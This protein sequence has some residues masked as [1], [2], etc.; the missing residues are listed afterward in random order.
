MPANRWLPWI[1][2]LC[3]ACGGAAKH[4]SSPAHGGVQAERSSVMSGPGEGDA[5]A[6]VVTTAD[7]GGTTGGSAAPVAAGQPAATVAGRQPV[8]EKMVIEGWIRVVV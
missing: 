5:E 3:T 1:V 7:D 2:S 6:A 8:P 4:A